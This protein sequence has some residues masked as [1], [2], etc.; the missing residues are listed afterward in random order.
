[1]KVTSSKS[2]GV[3]KK[4]SFG[5]LLLH[6]LQYTRLKKGIITLLSMS[7]TIIFPW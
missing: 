7:I 1:M 2:L 6:S 4:I 3:F 5:K